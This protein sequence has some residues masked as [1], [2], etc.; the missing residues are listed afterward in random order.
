MPGNKAMYLPLTDIPQ[1]CQDHSVGKEQV[2]ST[3]TSGTIEW[4][5]QEWICTLQLYI[6]TNWK[7]FEDL[8]VRVKIIKLLEENRGKSSGPWI[9]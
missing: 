2:S 7:W 5:Q 9:W 3:N 4:L 6:T 8:H 1:G